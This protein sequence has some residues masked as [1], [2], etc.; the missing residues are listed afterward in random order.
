MTWLKQSTGVTIKIGPFLDET[1]G[2]TPET[3]LTITASE[4][5]LSKNGGDIAAKAEAT[6]A[7]HDELGYYDVVLDATDTNT[8]GSLKLF[9]HESGA[10]PV[11]SEFMVLPANV[12]DSLFGSDKLQV[13]AVELSSDS[14]AADNAES[15]FDGTGYAGTNNT[16]PNV[17]TVNTLTNK[18]G[19][20]LSS[21][22]IL[23]I[24]HQ[25][26]TGI[27]TANTIG[28]LIE[29]NLDATISSRLAGASYTTPPTASDIATAV[30][31]SG[32]R[33]LTSFGTLIADIWSYATRTLTSAGAGGAT[34]EEVWEYATRTLTS[35]VP[36]VTEIRT[37]LDTNSTKLANLDA[38]VSSRSTLTAA[39]VW[40]ALTSGLTTV[41]SI[42]KLLVDRIDATISSR[43]A[44]S[45]Y[46]APD[47]AG[48]I[49]N[50]VWTNVTRTLTS[51]GS[52][53]ATAEEVWEY[54]DRTLTQT[55]PTV[56][57]IHT[58]LDTNSTKLANLD[59]TVSSRSTLTAQQVWDV[60]TSNLTAL[61]SIGKMLVDRIDAAITSRL[62]TS[63]YAAPPSVSAIRTEMDTNSTKLAL[64]DTNVSSRLADADYVAP[65]SASTVATAV[66]SNVT[67]TL[68]GGIPSAADIRGE[69]DNNSTKLTAIN[70]KVTNLPA[71]PASTSDVANYTSPL[72]T[73]VTAAAIKAKTDNLPASPA[74][75]SDIPSAATIAGAVET[76]LAINGVI[77]ANG[78]ITPTTITTATL[79][80]VADMVL[81]RSASN[82]DN[83][84]AENS[85]YELIQALLTGDTSSGA[86]VIYKTD[87]VTPFNSRVIGVDPNAV[88]VISVGVS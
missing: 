55:I 4:I 69:M 12:Y 1:D 52:G 58:E 32:T 10:L 28:R 36:T 43:L 38:T 41:G 22:G 56:T 49:A 68:T 26:L 53:G 67:R 2:I 82:V 44:A 87:G 85:L 24:W 65:D 19:F 23:A 46:T 37:E 86:W 66:W 35:G 40:D 76:E 15:F 7:T 80:A 73:Q 42:G 77:I 13:D 75:T 18:T 72:A 62:A 3:A 21:A 16:I 34:A 6:S 63:S 47:S 78:A 5:R 20:E 88:P 83:T 25:A 81:S 27:A 31:A 79:Q 64:L 45:G 54:A 61:G 59:T 51:S 33:T 74:A 48:T 39:Q 71:N 9:I 57:Q 14:V 30:W 50:A 84:A 11:W 70:N 8:L 17:T 60:L 29:D